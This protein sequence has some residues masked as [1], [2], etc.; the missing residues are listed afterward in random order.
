[1]HPEAKSK[2]FSLHLSHFKPV[3]FS[4]LHWHR[5]L[6]I[7]HL[8][9][10]SEPI[11][12]QLQFVTNWNVAPEF[13]CCCCTANTR[14]AITTT[15]LHSFN[16]FEAILKLKLKAFNYLYLPVSL[17][18]SLRFDR[19]VSV[20]NNMKCREYIIYRYMLISKTMFR[21]LFRVSVNFGALLAR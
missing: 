1:M 9:V 19:T 11:E 12:L 8:L 3:M 16:R 20:Y 5:P 17:N 7:S 15:K 13:C 14:V 6:N 21:L 10:S 18:I 4:F 2:W